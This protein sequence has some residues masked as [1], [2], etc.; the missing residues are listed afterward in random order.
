MSYPQKSHFIISV[1]PYLLHMGDG[2]LMAMNISRQKSSGTSQR[3]DTT[4]IKLKISYFIWGKEWIVTWG[5]L[6]K[7]SISYP[8]NQINQPTK[9]SNKILQ[10]NLRQ[11]TKSRESHFPLSISV[12]YDTHKIKYPQVSIKALIFC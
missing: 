6:L 4:E 12:R 1:I 11:Q 2:L 9:Q 7:L 8:F 10:I 3:A 5:I